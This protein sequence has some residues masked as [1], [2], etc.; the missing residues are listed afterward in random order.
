MDSL[1][2]LAGGFQ[3]AFSGYHLTLMVA[4]VTP[5]IG[6]SLVS[7][8]PEI[9]LPGTRLTVEAE[10]IEGDEMLVG[11]PSIY[12]DMTGSGFT[13][14]DMVATGDTWS[15]ELPAATCGTSPEFYMQVTGDGGGALI[16]EIRKPGV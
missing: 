9:V 1:Q 2:L 5:A 15:F 16:V 13:R 10:V 14:A 7:D 6:M 12:Y 11:V 8:V 3:T 4:G